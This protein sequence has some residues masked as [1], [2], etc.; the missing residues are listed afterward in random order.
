MIDMEARFR[1]IVNDQEVVNIVD[2]A[3][4]I[5]K[6]HKTHAIR[7]V[8]E[9]N[10]YSLLLANISDMHSVCAEI[11]DE[12]TELECAT[13]NFLDHISSY[14]VEDQFN[15]IN[16]IQN[17]SVS[18]MDCSDHI[19]TLLKKLDEIKLRITSLGRELKKFGSIFYYDKHIISD[20]DE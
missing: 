1:F 20:S 19:D 8:E 11:V 15:M 2:N 18:E 13:D 3:I 14:N 16:R 9:L 7:D 5:I 10:T 17:L 6:K 12:Q 4:D